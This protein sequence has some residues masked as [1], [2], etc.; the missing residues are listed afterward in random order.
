MKKS[1]RLLPLL[2]PF[3]FSSAVSAVEYKVSAG[4]HDF[5]VIDI[6]N[7]VPADRISAGT[8]HTFGIN[9]AIYVKHQMERGIKFLAK[10]EALLDN[11]KDHLDPDHISIWF[12]FLLDINGPVYSINDNHSFCRYVSA[13][14]KQNTVSC[15]EREVRQHFGLGYEFAKGG[16]TLDIN[17]YTGFYYIEIDDDTPVAR[18]YTRQNTDDGE[19]SHMF[20]I[21]GQ[22]DFNK[23]WS[24][25]AD[26]RRYATNAGAETLESNYEV[27]LACRNL[28]L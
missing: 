19:A 13:D 17:A 26:V 6:V 8:S 1:Y 3:L 7:D 27:F 11:D 20:Q 9:T 2:A 24:V 14:N 22:Y 18:G 4:L 16:L 28:D 15:I 5:V 25:R 10:A 12:D 21:K 23:D